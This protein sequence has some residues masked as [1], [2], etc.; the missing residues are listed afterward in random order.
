MSKDVLID[1]ESLH[2]HPDRIKKLIDRVINEIEKVRKEGYELYTL[3]LQKQEECNSQMDELSQKFRE[4]KSN[5]FGSSQ[6]SQFESYNEKGLNRNYIDS[7]EGDMYIGDLK[8][9]YDSIN[10]RLSKLNSS[11]NTLEN[12]A[13]Q[14]ININ[15]TTD[16]IKQMSEY[17]NKIYST[18]INALIELNN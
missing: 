3:T 12:I 5:Y 16:D 6:N 14:V 9:E 18:T 8:Q 13:Q 11:K 7:Q 10:D 17:W 2:S 4:G 15:K 1:I